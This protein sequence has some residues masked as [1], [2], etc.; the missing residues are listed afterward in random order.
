MTHKQEALLKE[1]PQIQ[2]KVGYK[3]DSENH[4]HTL[5]GKPLMGTST[6]VSVLAKPLTW[7]AA[8]LAVEKFGWLNPKK[9]TP[10]AVAEALSNGWN[11][12]K[13]LDLIQYELLLAEAYKAH[14][15]RLKDTAE[16]GTDLH[17]ELEKFVKYRMG[18]NKLHRPIFDPKIKPFVDWTDKNV[19]YFLWSEAHSFDE[20][21]WTGGISDAGAE[22]NNGQTAIFDFKS[23]KEAYKN[24]AI[25]AG[26]YVIQIEANGLWDSHGLNNKKL[27]KTI[28][29]I[30]IVPFGAEKVEP[31]LFADVQSY[32]EAFKAAVVL[33]KLLNFN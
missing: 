27:D 10:K 13:N 33:Y 26:G 14:S 25:Q 21:T 15:I 32:K 1:M 24:Q 9:N 31:V 28:D 6:I 11:K 20:G 19:K 4:I 18:L 3:F 2:N 5:L 22:L 23:S 29:S 17:K 8:G 12:I 16:A 30:F 7:W